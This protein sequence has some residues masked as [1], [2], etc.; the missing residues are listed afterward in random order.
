MIEPRTVTA[1]PD[2]PAIPAELR[3]ALERN[4]AALRELAAALGGEVRPI[5]AALREAWIAPTSHY[6]A[7]RVLEG[8]HRG[9]RA[10]VVANFLRHTTSGRGAGARV[11]W[12]AQH[13]VAIFRPDAAVSSVLHT[14][15]HTVPF[16]GELKVPHFE[17]GAQASSATESAWTLD[18]GP[19]PVPG[20]GGAYRFTGCYDGVLYATLGETALDRAGLEQALDALV[21]ASALPWR[22][23]TEEERASRRSRAMGRARRRLALGCLINLAVLGLIGW[24]IHA[25]LS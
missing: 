18:G 6:E 16:V 20:P 10:A 3:E 5:D 15:S 8:E 4:E 13:R 1:S 2:K 19:R 17:W 9:A 21:A 14:A 25:L 24:G 12:S 22:A 11:R 23:P 7:V